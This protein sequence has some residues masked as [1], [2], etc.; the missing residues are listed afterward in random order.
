MTDPRAARLAAERS[1]TGRMFDRVARTRA[2]PGNRVTLLPEAPEALEA[3]LALIASAE[4]WVHFDNYILRDDRIGRRFAAA[5]AGR[6]AA[7]VRVRV[8]V[9]WFG[10]FGTGRRYWRAL[11]EAGVEVRH[12]NPPRWALLGNLVRD[13]RKL[14]VADGARAITGGIC[15]GDEWVGDPSAGRQPWRDLALRIDGPAA[16]AIDQA[17]ARGWAV[18]GAPLP[19]EE[20]AAEVPAVGDAEVR[21]LA[22]EP[23]RTRT[24]RFAV[25]ALAGAA[26]RVWITDAYMV[27]PRRLADAMA[28]AAQDGVDVR[29][30]VPGSSDLPYVRNLTRIGYRGLLRAGVR[31]FEWSG[32]MLHAK[33]GVT[34][35]RWV[36]IGSTNLNWYSFVGNWELDILV[37]DHALGAELEAVFRFDLERSAEVHRRPLRAPAR[38]RQ[39]LPPALAIEEPHRAA[40]PGHRPG[41]RERGRRRMVEVRALV[42]SARRAWYGTIAAALFGVALLAFIAPRAAGLLLGLMSAMV[43]LLAARG[44][45]GRDDA[46]R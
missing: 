35:G 46:D 45:V 30:L 11:R 20:L 23:G 7:G 24:E 1:K 29:L 14:V 6:A 25:V 27:A 22:G 3:M 19:S 16:A 8:L 18:T 2:I 44:A 37:E 43:G 39:L 26:E 21:V 5:F 28:D 4:R 17:F 13:H 12:F 31:I 33:A 40:M 38:L 42:T 34:D 10:S 41:W 32:P 9:D 36:R 15:I